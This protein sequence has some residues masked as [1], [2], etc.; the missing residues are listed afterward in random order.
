MCGRVCDELFALLDEHGEV[1]EFAVLHDQVDVLAAFDAV[2]EGD[3]V[4]VSEA[5]EDLDF[6]IEVLF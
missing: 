6:P 2:V 3:D 5:L 4:W 1:A